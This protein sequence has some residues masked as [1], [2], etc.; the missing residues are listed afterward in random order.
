MKIH[1]RQL[2]PPLAAGALVLAAAALWLAAPWREAEP[3]A[4]EAPPV[5]SVPGYRT[6]TWA[7]LLPPGW[8]PHEG[9]SAEDIGAL[10]DD[11]P[12]AVELMQRMRWDEAPPHAAMDGLPVNLAGYVVPLQQAGRALK[13][14]LLVP[15][16]GACIH[17][18]PPPANQIVHVT[19]AEPA[20][21]LHAMDA[22]WVRGPLQARRVDSVMGTSVYTLAA[23]SVEKIVQ[24]WRWN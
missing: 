7:D 3:Q 6:I 20:A 9:L 22:V 14:F 2:L 4:A 5:P 11:D 23:G 1:R 8:H 24:P 19:L 12:R 17:T 18:P 13:E 21:N 10:R 15:H 16:F